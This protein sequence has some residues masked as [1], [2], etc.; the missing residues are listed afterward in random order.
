MCGGPPPNSISSPIV[1]CFVGDDK[2]QL[3][4]HPPAFGV[5]QAAPLTQLL[6]GKHVPRSI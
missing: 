2:R 4:G 1:G 5:V 6:G 3:P